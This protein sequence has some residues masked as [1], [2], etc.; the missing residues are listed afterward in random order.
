[1]NGQQYRTDNNKCG[2]KE[3]ADKLIHITKFQLREI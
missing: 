3:L 1:M 2:K